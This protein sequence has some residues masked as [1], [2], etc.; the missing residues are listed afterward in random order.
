MDTFEDD[1]RSGLPEHVDRESYSFTLRNE[2]PSGP[3]FE[4][5]PRISFD[6]NVS[7]LECGIRW[8]LSQLTDDSQLSTSKYRFEVTDETST[9]V[10]TTLPSSEHGYYLPTVPGAAYDVHI[11]LVTRSGEILAKGNGSFRAVFSREEIQKL[12][13]KALEN[14]RDPPRPFFALYRCKPKRYFDEVHEKYGGVMRPYLKDNNGQAA[15]PINGAIQGIFFATRLLA[16][17][18]IPPASP[19]GEV[20]MLVPAFA[21][22]NPDIMNFYFSDYYCN[23]SV[24]YLTIVVTLKDSETDKFCLQR[25]I[26]LPTDN[27]FLRIERVPNCDDSTPPGYRYRYFVNQQVWVELYFTEPVSLSMGKFS[28]IS[29]I[30]SGSSTSGGLPHNKEC[31]VCNLYPVKGLA[32]DKRL[33]VPAPY[34]N[35]DPNGGIARTEAARQEAEKEEPRS[36]DS[37]SDLADQLARIHTEIPS[38]VS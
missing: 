2:F 38:H 14:L 3:H 30:G 31:T 4:S 29:V 35:I 13:Q 15:S 32:A 18:S 26:P 6:Y 8:K 34:S 20:R 27:P 37:V 22:L 11:T 21:M 1:L 10:R 5:F 36:N 24:H 16:D 28:L 33:P 17:G 12:Y 19:F 25:L 9:V 23:Y 7:A